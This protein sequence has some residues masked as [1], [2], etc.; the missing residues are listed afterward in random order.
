MSSSDEYD[1]RSQ[2][3]LTMRARRRKRLVRY[4]D[5]A[6]PYA[7]ITHCGSDRLSAADIGTSSSELLPA[8]ITESYESRYGAS[9]AS[10]KSG[11]P[12]YVSYNRGWTLVSTRYPA[13]SSTAVCGASNP[14]RPDLYDTGEYPVVVAI[15]AVRLAS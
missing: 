12:R 10:T 2:H 1:G 3:V 8:R 13:F 11:P 4:G 6:R 7:R 5:G 14:N 9:G 15:A